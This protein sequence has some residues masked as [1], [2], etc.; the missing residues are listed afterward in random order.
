MYIWLEYL[1]SYNCAKKMII[2][3]KLLFKMNKIRQWKYSYDC[4][5]IFRNES[6]FCFE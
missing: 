1:I 6:T 2:D 5:E 3:E 4:N